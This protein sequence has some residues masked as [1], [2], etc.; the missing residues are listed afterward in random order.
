MA[1]VRL[2]RI[3]CCK[4]G[5]SIEP[6]EAN[7]CITCLSTEI[8]ITK[9]IQRQ[10]TIVFCPKCERY[11][12]PP[13]QW[14]T[15]APESA[16]LLSMC[17]KRVKGLNKGL[18][19]RGAKFIWTEPHSKRINVEVTV[20]GELPTGDMVEQDIPL[21]FVVHSQQC[22]DCT[23]SA[24]KDYWNACVQVRQRVDHKRTLMHLEQIILRS[25]AHG[26]C[27]AIKQVSDGID[28]YFGTRSQA[29][30]FVNF[31][32]KHAPCRYQTSQHLKSHDVHNNTYNYKF[33]FSVEVAGICKNDIVCL[34]K[35]QSQ[36]FGGLGPLCVV[37]KVSEAIHLIDPVTCQIYHLDGASFF[38]SPFTAIAHQKQLVPFVVVEIEEEPHGASKRLPSAPVGARLSKR[39]QPISVWLMR[40]NQQM[41]VSGADA[42]SHEDGMIHARCHLGRILH[43]GD[44]VFGLDIRN[45]NVNHP[46]FQKLEE[47][48]QVPDVILVLRPRQSAEDDGSSVNRG[49]SKAKRRRKHS[50]TA[51]SVT[52]AS[53]VVDETASM[54]TET[55]SQM[56]FSDYSDDDGEEDE[57]EGAEEES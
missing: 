8:D 28:F 27:S 16:E 52:A 18:K 56:E 12:N 33:T 4:C 53:S 55:D 3:L 50:V 38:A 30:S 35:A 24:A 32:C 10:N 37:Y 40:L 45:C 36:R 44:T 26:D 9:H 23:R 7:T 29:V 43:V 49:P 54:M 46:E 21:E 2:H 11:L 41:T 19:V 31:L 22:S 1:C 17:I 5:V 34:S 15:A 14:V 47:N 42:D 20:H 39:H 57:D 51:T 6:N 48:N 13:S 25:K